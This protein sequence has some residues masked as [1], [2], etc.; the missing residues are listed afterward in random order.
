MTLPAPQSD[1]LEAAFSQILDD[2]KLVPEEVTRLK[3]LRHR[4]CME[5]VFRAL[6]AALPPGPEPWRRFFEAAMLASLVGERW[7]DTIRPARNDFEK[8]RAAALRAGQNLAAALRTLTDEM[9]GFQSPPELKRPAKLLALAATRNGYTP[10]EARQLAEPLAEDEARRLA[11]KIEW[12][13]AA[14]HDRPAECPAPVAVADLIA[15]MLHALED[16]KPARDGDMFPGQTQG[17]KPHQAYVRALAHG[18]DALAGELGIAPHGR[19]LSYDNLA[20]VTRA[21][22]YLPDEPAGY[23]YRQP[24]DGEDVRRALERSDGSIPPVFP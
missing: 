14:P 9:H 24:F 10:D 5:K 8:H 1:F 16:W 4:P 22:L 3:S 17:G 6:A 11:G 20:R 23:P 19:L 2:W 13:E 18:L 12:F 7:G 15:A 21:A